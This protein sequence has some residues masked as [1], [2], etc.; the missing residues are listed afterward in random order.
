MATAASIGTILA[1][2]PWL[3][4]MRTGSCARSGL[5][6]SVPGPAGGRRASIPKIMEVAD[7]ARGVEVEHERPPR[8]GT[9]PRPGG[10]AVPGGT[11]AG[12][13]PRRCRGPRR[14]CRRGRAGR[15][16]PRRGGDD[17]AAHGRSACSSASPSS[18]STARTSLACASWRS[19]GAQQPPGLDRDKRWQIRSTPPSRCDATTI[20]M[21]NSEPI[22]SMARAWRCDG[23]GQGRWSARQA[24]AAGDRR[25]VPG[26][27]TAASCRWSTR[28]SGGT[29][30]EPNV[31]QRLA[32][33]PLATGG[34]PA[35]AEVGDELGG[36]H[37]GGR[38]LCPACSR[39][40]S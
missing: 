30:V 13:G 37:V 21:P 4:L 28:R 18:T 24:A 38:Q 9:A 20:Q 17:Q 29:L 19:V 33:R 40:G 2:M 31:A 27:S 6:R 25:S 10:G 1:L 11:A 32:A 22:R 26:Q 34:S 16:V 7:G 14:R 15:A 12:R 36:G 35:T 8:R 5:G 3:M 39:A 23:P